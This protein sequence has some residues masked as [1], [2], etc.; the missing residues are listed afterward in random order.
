MLKLVNECFIF[1]LTRRISIKFGILNYCT[2]LIQVRVD[3]IY[4]T[5]LR[6][7]VI[8]LSEVHIKIT[9]HCTKTVVY[10]LKIL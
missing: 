10:N 2:Y 7:A 6:E 5:T 3:P 8:V 1:K 4:A 9:S